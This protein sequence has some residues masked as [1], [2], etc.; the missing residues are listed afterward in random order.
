MNQETIIQL[1]NQASETGKLDLCEQQLTALPTE[2]FQLTHLEELYLDNNQI[3]ELPP[4]IAQFTALRV[5]SL[6]NNQ[7]TILP[8]AMA[9]LANLEWL[10]LA[11]NQFYQLPLEITQLSQLK[12]L[13]LDSN[14]LTALPKEIIE[15]P[16][17]KVLSCHNNPLRFPPP[18]IIAQGTPEILTYLRQPNQ[19]PQWRAKLLVVG[20]AGVGKTSLLNQLRDKTFSQQE[21]STF[22]IAVDTWLLKHPSQ[23]DTMMQLKTWDFGGQIIYHATHQFFLTDKAL[24]V[25]VWNARL[26]YEQGKLTYWLETIQNRA[27]KSPVLLVATHID[28]GYEAVLP[29]VELTQKYPQIVGHQCYKV[30]NETGEGIDI[31]AQAIATAAAQLPLMGELWPL[32]WITVANAIGEKTENSLTL[33]ELQALMTDH[34]LATDEST[35][36][37]TWLHEL[38]ELLYFKENEELKNL[39]I[40]KPQWVTTHISW[41]LSSKEVIEKQGILTDSHRDALWADLTYEMR[42]HFLNLMEQFD[43]SYRALEDRHTSFIVECLPQDPADYQTLWHTKQHAQEIRMTYELTNMNHLPPGIPTWFIARSHR[44]TT[45]THWRYGALFAD[46]AAHQHLGLVRALPEAR[47]IELAVR[48]PFPHHFFAVLR[49]GLELTLDR[50]PGLQIKRKIPCLGHQGRSCAGEFDYAQLEKALEKKVMEIQCQEA[51]E[52]VSVSALLF[53]LDSRTQN[54]MLQEKLAELTTAVKTKEQEKEAQMVSLIELTQH[55]LSHQFAH[56]QKQQDSQCPYIFTLSEGK[57][58]WWRPFA[59]REVKLQLYCQY[60]GEPHP[61]E[62]GGYYEIPEFEKWK[63]RLSPYLSQ[64]IGLYNAIMS[65][66]GTLGTISYQQQLQDDLKFM[67]KLLQEFSGIEHIPTGAMQRSLC[68][69]LKELDPHQQWGGLERVPTPEGHVLWLCERHARYFNHQQLTIN[70]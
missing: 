38:G 1:I 20:E 52:N 6:T 63:Y 50:F 43:L 33:N 45:H 58:K 56:S 57:A 3:T 59:T 69:L 47:K 46:N 17:I 65:L 51:F 32:P 2:I 18:E 21:E 55:Q 10:Y 19:Q 42:E 4:E 30:S 68:L 37:T 8:T 29:L 31:I 44:F 11:N 34:G 64:L 9:Q 14:Q 12:V 36:L 54:V 23:A 7:L 48:G 62:F 41:V 15:L 16:H 53:G 61:T 26:G 67:N 66:G 35:I 22:G 13:S 70:H 28:Q 40:L 39:V 49:D 25:L 27:P 5:L 60:P 24:F